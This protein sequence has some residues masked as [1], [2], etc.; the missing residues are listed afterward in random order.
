MSVIETKKYQ[1][2]EV[3]NAQ[4]DLRILHP[5]TSAD[6]VKYQDGNTASNVKDKLDSLDTRMGDVEGGVSTADGKADQAIE[7]A[8]NAVATAEGKNKAY[9]CLDYQA[10]STTFEDDS[11]PP[12]DYRFLNSY[13]VSTENVVVIDSDHWTA[14]KSKANKTTFETSLLESAPPELE[15]ATATDTQFIMPDRIRLMSVVDAEADYPYDL[16]IDNIHSGDVLYIGNGDYPDRWVFIDGTYDD[17]ERE[18]TTINKIMLFKVD[19]SVDLSN[20]LTATQTNS[21]ITTALGQHSGIDKV[22][23]VTSVTV[24]AGTGISVS[25]GTVTSSG[26]ITVALADSGVTAGTYSAVQV[27]AKG[28]VTAGGQMVAVGGSSAP[29]DLAVGGIWFKE[30]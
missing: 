8:Q 9:G 23:T 22:G 4:G 28:R 11:I 13:L 25:N 18:W 26:T 17:S 7:L 24:S 12:V 14:L 3:A 15:A 19:T 5:E 29:A 30:V 1:I 6:N 2:N 10:D 21:A 27:D 20:Y 16:S